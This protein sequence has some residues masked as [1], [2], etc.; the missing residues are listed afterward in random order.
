MVDKKI[1]RQGNSHAI[2]LPLEFLNE[3]GLFAGDTAEVSLDSVTKEIIIRNAKTAP[4]TEDNRFDRLVKDAVEKYLS[5][6]GL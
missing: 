3:L 4:L 1:R 2:Y 5:S 6:R